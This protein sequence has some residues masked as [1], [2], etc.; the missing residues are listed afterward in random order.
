MNPIIK[1]QELQEFSEKE[2]DLVIVD[3]SNGKEARY[4]YEKKHLDKAIFVDLNSQLADIKDNFSQGGRHPLPKIEDFS[5]ILGKIGISKHTH[6]VIYDDKNGA[7][8]AARFWWMLKAAGHKKVQVLDGGIQK[9]EQS[10]Y[11]VNNHKVQPVPVADYPFTKW[12]LPLVEMDEIRKTNDLIID[13]REENRYLGISEPIDQIAGHIP[14]AVNFP[15]PEN[16]NPDG[17]FLTPVQLKEKYTKLLKGRSIEHVIVHCG[18][19]VTACHTI[20]ALDYAGLGNPKLY[21]GSWSEWS[22]NENKMATGA[23]VD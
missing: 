11:P 14:G 3:V 8:A 22:R 2:K 10:G 15:F 18:S 6:V 21:V 16:L 5:E 19:G 7:N 13:V 20:L 9:A 23:N 1:V 17:T 4:N 12:E